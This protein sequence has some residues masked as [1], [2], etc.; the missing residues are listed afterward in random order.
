MSLSFVNIK[1]LRKQSDFS[2]HISVV[3]GLKK[4]RKFWKS[5]NKNNIYK[6]HLAQES[7]VRLKCSPRVQYQPKLSCQN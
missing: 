2:H 4:K 1:I 5:E 3:L 6:N 7:L